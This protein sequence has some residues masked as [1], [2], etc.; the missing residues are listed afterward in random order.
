MTGDKVRQ[1]CEAMWPQE[2]IDALCKPFGV[3]ERQ[4]KLPRGMF[5]RARAISAGTPG[6]AYQADVLPSYLPCEVPPVARSVRRAVRGVPWDR[7]LR[8]DPSAYAAP[9]G[10]LRGAGA[11]PLQSGP[12]A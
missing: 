6:G 8:G 4:R 11:V 1:V 2:E 3:V 12:R 9:L 5:V 7:R 10:R